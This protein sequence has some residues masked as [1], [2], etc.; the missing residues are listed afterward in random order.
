MSNFNY[1]RD[2]NTY[3]I[4]KKQLVYTST[5]KI[6]NN[7]T[8]LS[9]INDIDLSVLTLNDIVVQSN[10]QQLTYLDTTK[11]IA[12]SNKALI[13]DSSSN[14]ENINNI[15]CNNLI[16][17][18]QNILSSGSAATSSNSPYLQ[19]IITGEGQINKVLTTNNFNNVKNINTLSSTSLSINNSLISSNIGTIT[20]IKS[21][22]TSWSIISQSLLTNFTDICW[23][24]ELSLGIIISNNNNVGRIFSSTDGIN[25]TSRTA[26]VNYNWSSICW[27]PE[28]SL[29]VIVSTSGT[30]NRV[31]TSSNGIDWTSRISAAD[32]EW[33]SVC[34]SPDL[35]L[36]VAVAKTGT[37]NRIMTSPN[38]IT[39]TIRTSPA[40]NSWNSVCWS[41]E[42]SLF[43][44]VSIDGSNRSM[45]SP[46][47]IN[48]TIRSTTG[49]NTW[50]SIDWSP[51]LGYFVSVSNNGYIMYSSTGTSWSSATAPFGL[52][53]WTKV[54]WIPSLNI[55]ILTSN[56]YN[57]IGFSYN[58][59]NWNVLKIPYT[60]PFI[61][62]VWATSLNKLII[63]SSE[64]TYYSNY[65]L[66]GS[67]IMTTNNW[68][69][70]FTKVNSSWNIAQTG[71]DPNVELQLNNSS[72]GSSQTV[73]YYNSRIQDFANLTI[74]FNIKLSGG[75]DAT[76]FNIGASNSSTSNM[77]GDGPNSPAFCMC[78]QIY[79]SKT[80]GIYFYLNGSQIGFYNVTVNDNVYNSVTISYTK[81]TTNTWV[82]TY[83][84]TNILN[85]SDSS[86]SSW[87]TTSGSYWGFGCRNG[88]ITHDAYIKNFIIDSGVLTPQN[89][90]YQG[91]KIILSNNIVSN[92]IINNGT[93]SYNSLINNNNLFNTY[94]NSAFS[95]YIYALEWS[96]SL[97]LLVGVG[98]NLIIT[99]PDGI[100]W[101]PRTNPNTNTHAGIC[102]SP[103]LSL[104]VV[105]SSSGTGN[106]V[107]TSP[108]GITWTSR[109][110]ANDNNWNAVCWSPSL[111]LFAA[112]ASSGSTNYRIMTS[113]D[114]ITW[115][116]ILTSSNGLDA[117]TWSPELGMFSVV[118]SSYQQLYSYDGINWISPYSYTGIYSRNICWS[119][120]LQMFVTLS[121]NSNTLNYSYDGINWI[122]ITSNAFN[123]YYW[124]GL[125]WSPELSIFIAIS[126]GGSAGSDRIA[127]SYN[128]I[129][130][131]TVS[132][133]TLSNRNWYCLLWISDLKNF[134]GMS[135]NYA[136]TLT[137]YNY[138]FLSLNNNANLSA[139]EYNINNNLNPTSTL[140]NYTNL[141]N[142]TQF[143]TIA[144]S[145][146]L[147][148]NVILS[149]SGYNN[150]VLTSS[151]CITW[152]TQSTPNDNN[153]TSI[154]W[155]SLLNL[156][157]AVSN[158]GIGNRVMTSPNGINWTARTTPVDNNWTSICWAS[159]ITLFVAVSS[160]GIDNR[161]MTS[162]DGINWTSRIS[163]TNNNWTSVCWSPSLA[164]FVAVASSG[165]GDR[166]MTSPDGI[167][168]T[169]RISS[170]DT[171]WNS[172]CWS[173]TLNLFVAVGNSN[174][175]MIMTSPDGITWTNRNSSSN[176]DWTSICWSP[177]LSKFIA[178]ANI[179]NYTNLTNNILS[180]YMTSNSSNN[181]IASAST[182]QT[183]WDPYRV[184]DKNVNSGWACTDG[185]YNTSSGVYTSTITTTDSTSTIHS[186]EWIQM[187]FS[188]LFVLGSFS[189]VPRYTFENNRCP[190]SFVLLGSNN[191]SIWDV[192]YTETNK[193]KWIL[194][195]NI[196]NLTNTKAYTYYRL[197]IKRVGIL[198]TG[199]SSAGC[200]TIT[201]WNFISSINNNTIMSSTDGI[202]W[203]SNIISPETNN[204]SSIIWNGN[205]N[206]LIAIASSGNNGNQIMTSPNINNW[207]THN[208][209]NIS[210]ICYS[211]DLNQLVILSQSGTNNL[212]YTSSDIYN[213]NYQTSP[214]N[215]NWTSI[216]WSGDL[217]MY[218]AVASSGS[219][220]RVMTSSNGTIWTSRTSA[221]NNNWTSI[222]WSPELGLFVA[223]ASSG[224]SNRIMTSN[225]GI[226]WVSRIS[227]ID[228]NWT[229]VCWSPELGLFVAVASS[230]ISNRIM[231]SY[232]GTNWTSRTSPINNNWTSV[233]WSA[234]LR[235][236]VAV[237]NSGNN[238]R[239]MISSNG[240]N[241]TLQ[242]SI[243]NNNYVSITWSDEFHIFIAIANSGT[244]RLLISN[245][246]IKW[247]AKNIDSK[248]WLSIIWCDH[249]GK[250][251][252]IS[253]SGIK[254]ILYST[255]PSIGIHSKILNIS[256]N[257]LKMYTNNNL[258]FGL[259]SKN[260]KLSIAPVN[261]TT[262]KTLRLRYN[263]STTNYIDFTIDTSVP[264]QYNI[265]NNSNN[266]IFNIVNHNAS[267][268]G[269]SLQ[270]T[271]LPV[272]ATELNLLNSPFG[273]ASPSKV[274]ITNSLKNMS[275]LNNIS[276][277]SAIVNN[278]ILASSS[279][280]N[281]IYLTD[282]IIGIAS[283]N[284]GLIVDSSRN[285]TNLNDLEVNKIILSNDYDI[286]NNNLKSY[287][288]FKYFKNFDTNQYNYPSNFDFN[289]I[290]WAP[291]LNL[292]V[293]I[294]IVES[295]GV[296]S[297]KDQ[298]PYLVN[299]STNG[300]SW[301]SV[302]LPILS[303]TIITSNKL[304]SIAWAPSISTFVIVCN[305]IYYNRS[306]ISNDGYNWS[307]INTNIN[308]SW[309]S[310]CWSPSLSL[311]V[312]V[313]SSGTGNRVMTS[314]DGITWT[315][316]TSAADNS[317][318]YI[319]WSPEL[320]LFVAVASSGTGNRVMTSSNGTTWTTRTSA[321]DNSWNSVCWSSSLTLFVAVASS[322]TSNRIMTSPN[323]TTWTSRTSP[324][325]NNWLQ[326]AWVPFL[327]K[328]IAVSDSITT[329]VIYSSNGINWF[330][331]TLNYNIDYSSVIWNSSLN[332]FITIAK[333]GNLSRILTSTNGIDWVFRNTPVFNSFSS[334]V[335]SPELNLY[336]I[337]SYDGSNNQILTSPDSITWTIRS[338]A[339]TYMKTITWSPSL[340]LFV[341]IGGSSGTTYNPGMT[342]NTTSSYIASASSILSTGWDAYTAFDN[343]TSTG[344][345]CNEFAYNTSTG[346]YLLSATTT[347]STSTVHSGEWIQIQFL[348]G[349]ITVNNIN[350]T[351]R[352]GWET[353]R[354]PRSFVL[355]GSNNGTTW[356]NIYTETNR[357]NWTS[358]INNVSILAT[359]S[360]SYYRLVVKRVGNYD[361]GMT[362]SGSIQIME[363]NFVASGN[364]TML[365]S[366]DGITWNSSTISNTQ[367]W[368]SIVW[369]PSLSLFVAI[370]SEGTGN[371]VM[372]SSNGITWTSRTSA[373]DNTWNSIC[374]SP[375][376]S[377]FVAVSADGSNNRVMTSSDGI[378][379]TSRTS[380]ANNIWASVCWSAS[381]TLFVA[382]STS[383]TGN[384]VMTSPDGINWTSRNTPID[385]QWVS[386]S[387]SSLLSLFVAVASSGTDTR[388]MTSSDGIN[389]TYL[390]TNTYNNYFTCL[391][392]SSSP[393]LLLMGAKRNGAD[394]AM[395]TKIT[396][397]SNGMDFNYADTSYDL[398]WRDMIYINE[399]SLF[400]TVADSNS[401]ISKQI[402]RSSDGE[403][404]TYDYISKNENIGFRKLFWV[405]SLNT[406]FAIANTSGLF[407]KSSNGI[408]WTK[409]IV[410]GSW[411]DISWSSSLSLLIICG[412]GT[413]KIAI[414]SDS[415]ITW[416]YPILPTLNNIYSIDWSPTLNLFVAPTSSSIG[417]YLTST[418][419]INWSSNY[420]TGN[421]NYS[422]LK[423]QWIPEL[424]IFMIY[425]QSTN[426][427]YYTSSNGLN[428]TSR[429]F[430]ISNA[431]T[432]TTF[433]LITYNAEPIWI[434][435][436]N[437]LYILFTNNYETKLLES[438]DGITWEQNIIIPSHGNYS[439]LCWA[440]SIN[441]LIGFG[442]YT[443]YTP[444][445]P[446]IKLNNYILP[447][448]HYNISSL[449]Q[450]NNNNYYNN[451]INNN[452]NNLSQW[453]HKTSSV[454]N[455][456]TSVCYSYELNLFVAV[457]SSGTS[458]RIMTSTDFTTW[459]TRTS[460]AD[461]NWTSVCW[462]SDLTLFVAVASSGTANRVMTSSDGITWTIRTSAIDNNWTSVCWSSELSIFV[463][464]ASSG[465]G[466]RIMYS[467]DG[468]AWFI[469]SSPVDN[470]WTSVCYSY[471]LNLFV[472]VASS[473][474]G[475]RVMT[476][477][478][479]LIWTT[480]I[481]P[482][483][484]NW[485]SVCWS[486]NL[487]LFVA[488]ASTGT[489]NRV[490]SSS[491]GINWTSR[492]SASDNAWTS[493]CW[494]PELN[495]F[496]AIAN[497]DTSGLTGSNIISTNMINNISNN[498]IASSSSVYS[499]NTPYLAFD[500]NDNTYWSCNDPL[501]DLN[502]GDYIGNTITI[503]DTATSHSGEWL[504]IKFPNSIQ[505]TNVN[506][507]PKTD[508]ILS[509][510]PKSFI[511]FGSNNGT[512]WTS[513]YS[514]TNKTDWVSGSNNI[515]ITGASSY[516][517]YRMI[518]KKVT[519]ADTNQ[520]IS[521]SVQISEWI[522]TTPPTD[523]RIMTSENGISWFGSSVSTT[524]NW[525]SICWSDGY[526]MAVAVSSTGTGNRVLI[527]SLTLPHQKS[528]ALNHSSSI[529]I[530]ESNGNIGLGGVLN[531]TGQLEL[532]NDSAAKP[533]SAY[534]TISSDIR[535][536]EEIEDADLDICYNNLDNL[537]LVKYK[538]KDEIIGKH[539]LIDNQQLGWIADEVEKIFPNSITISNSDGIEDC[540]LLDSD[541]II[542]TMYGT[543]QKLIQN[544]DN[545]IN[546]MND[547][548]NKVQ[549]LNDFI[550]T[551]AIE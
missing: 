200:V 33:T 433:Y 483:N 310:V 199:M 179:T 97:K 344:W 451:K 526:K 108:D 381:L 10:G 330:D 264:N 417:L 336:V 176:N 173:S 21:L 216:C 90:D 53:A 123:N 24:N 148:L 291:E 230:G 435:K 357:T 119:S 422:T 129:D 392:Y 55:F 113:P 51:I 254:N 27:S 137:Q 201:E 59:I 262:N 454:D 419:G 231:T 60:Y 39:W 388:F 353:T 425:Y 478:D 204:W 551:L 510:S 368:N 406:I 332:H 143:S 217:N 288:T 366:S 482:V 20:N 74:S 508:V 232:N 26:P 359:S 12:T 529:Y 546:K 456:W 9:N 242:D 30:G 507:K 42:L 95:N 370:S 84:G 193:V 17:N 225:D 214:I 73:L 82:V 452:Y 31:L 274:L 221:A 248:N 22:P 429:T 439:S 432:A 66:Q 497:N 237:A 409:F 307:I 284:K 495:S 290:I 294:G 402:A 434:N 43:S 314:P 171:N 7:S 190:R 436:F 110:S 23:S 244:D 356:I 331:F 80:P 29:F 295:D 182:S 54:K 150:R 28:L 318:N 437:K 524:N 446:F 259:N 11:G 410:T 418:D 68:Y 120:T 287:N 292:Y 256:N 282:P 463:A 116:Q 455:N 85:Y 313:A 335:W 174:I 461:N 1:I 114:G 267:T 544:Y 144:Y 227:P 253:D 279:D 369:A 516:S 316:R 220:N 484:N 442:Y 390:N 462:S 450:E 522:F 397:T 300:L 481:S 106:R 340:N 509:R 142:N 168:W 499:T 91:S 350:I 76:S 505:I 187:Q 480:N 404:W 466:N 241:W 172:V 161:V 387:W 299:V 222:C 96:P 32:N 136:I 62:F 352:S 146:E 367:T 285:I 540:K 543:L 523:Y 321:A 151:N 398:K 401:K 258:N 16:V 354:G 438:S 528:N 41:S 428:W 334:I 283:S 44:S 542:S 278:K 380:A 378:N 286:Q 205:I 88:G 170:Y 443:Y 40:D 530:N 226:V 407:Y 271:I 229:S 468:F 549:L 223:V 38:G 323:G 460:P 192:L 520:N 504:Q 420:L 135:Y 281:S 360:Y 470:N 317:W 19:N 180:F 532:L 159:D 395:Y 169:S 372:T 160:S 164:L 371:R 2:L 337:V 121:Y 538:W 233:C 117:I 105:V 322:G 79:M 511:I 247:Y 86:N 423:I 175:Y 496:I 236:F 539:H 541:Q 156:F 115:T 459:T 6:N 265:V 325:D 178:I 477:T 324:A 472:A 210:C 301:K 194:G 75:A 111:S 339:Q 238:D 213:W 304:T 386:V 198:D 250:F 485:T 280:N 64:Y 104:F 207:T 94:Y 412:T 257:S 71:S 245:N 440:N 305:N 249:L 394:I 490:M 5:P 309:N 513:L 122:N 155:A 449:N 326:V 411:Y 189:L 447:T 218:A 149:N 385:N 502:S 498:L 347:D 243:N 35:T 78:F 18:N 306:Y 476:S 195:K 61:S 289:N 112:V 399:L 414:S 441:T 537:R 493:I 320:S 521:T 467:P 525:N 500:G 87:L 109:T 424:N 70:L 377:L 191:G 374:W 263:N 134:I 251:I 147:D 141:N 157:V 25:W 391:T 474:T 362:D 181:M 186:G 444:N 533:S 548:Q 83:K 365:S 351:L 379:W 165:T 421:I 535:L 14:I 430:Y 473:G 212:I 413:N 403:N 550:N 224:I 448:N 375:E 153:W 266:K 185:T 246:G 349:A 343:T 188:T 329:N 296:A 49:A 276:L 355:L 255:N 503:D 67:S 127:F 252:G 327:S 145:P 69:S 458:N 382:V 464:V 162:S 536:K 384:R 328:F 517:Y 219:G 208:I 364:N 373:A 48:W 58:A 315:S 469:L 239:I 102:W 228:N 34:W 489:G 107:I 261:T 72:Y 479:G 426:T 302:S 545:Q 235:L 103:S 383:G 37:N 273:I 488:V 184:F 45:S 277:N 269:L 275:N 358:G 56:L 346:I 445:K 240:I 534:W 471:E 393:N 514:N 128:G 152:I 416:T 527:N 272:T 408:T 519:N 118:G 50:V 63:V 298:Y 491:D 158:S 363:M 130:W 361:S 140:W 138:N 203:D 13:L 465:V 139:I 65:V 177:Y 52:T 124:N 101:T 506:I 341:A 202:I 515:T 389:W 131:K 215:N 206:K 47:G 492:I 163:A 36:F 319:C 77:Y 268:Y 57:Y 46:D 512:T 126:G 167:N 345:H 132:I 312:A 125:T 453:F 415:G 89:S 196:F 81:G 487:N 308:N 400:I 260:Y 183:S 100:T 15:S 405:S 133:N 92:E 531:P 338:S 333:T 547:I 270:G 518:I 297:R 293:A 494:A 209:Y 197:V 396:T 99:S 303:N 3:K 376:L 154:C 311:F 211:S 4:I 486:S 342:S 166:V 234:Y 93:K 431:P 475:N 457:A 98:A 348:N 501:Y 8:V 427:T